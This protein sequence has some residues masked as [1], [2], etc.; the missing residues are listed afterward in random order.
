MRRPRGLSFVL[1]IVA[2]FLPRGLTW[3]LSWLAATA[4]S[5]TGGGRH[6]DCIQGQQHRAGAPATHSCVHSSHCMRGG[7]AECCGTRTKENSHRED[8]RVELYFIECILKVY[9]PTGHGDAF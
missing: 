8:V 2:L 6:A 5:Y 9:D 4:Q 1:A 3:S 7:S